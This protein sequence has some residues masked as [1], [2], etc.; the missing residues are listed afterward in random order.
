VKQ[1]IT[2]SI[3]IPASSIS[4]RAYGDGVVTN[5]EDGR[6]TL[7]YTGAISEPTLAGLHKF[8]RVSVSDNW[9][10]HIAAV[11]SNQDIAP[12]VCVHHGSILAPIRN[13]HGESNAANREFAHFEPHRWENFNHLLVIGMPPA[14]PAQI[15]FV[16]AGT[17]RDRPPTVE[18][19]SNGR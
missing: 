1:D 3:P 2:D 7:D 19:V 8:V 18:V 9:F 10:V 15:E 6:V 12:R 16:L 4:A 5:I 13:A 17:R 11:A 14:G